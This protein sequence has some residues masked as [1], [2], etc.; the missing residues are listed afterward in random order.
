MTEPTL[1]PFGHATA[2]RWSDAAGSVVQQMGPCRSEHRLGFVYV[3]A[4][5]SEEL[6]NISIFLR[7][8]TGVETWVGTVGLGVCATGQEYFQ[9][10]AI[11]AMAVPID[12]DGFRLFGGVREDA[13]DV[14]KS[15]AE[16][17]A[18][19][20]MPLVVTHGDPGNRLLPALIEDLAEET[21]GFLVGGL[22][23]GMG[24]ARQLA[25][26]MEQDG[27]SGVML[28]P[29]AVQV[30]TGLT[31]GCTPIGPV[32]RITVAEDNVLIEIDERPALDV[33][34]EDI[35]KDMAEDLNKVAG[36]IYAGLPIEG[37]DVGDYTVRNLIGI[38]PENDMIAIGEHVEAGDTVLFCRRDQDSAVEDMKRMLGD[39]KRRANGAPIRGGLYFTCLARGANQF[40]PD[41][42]ELNMI[43]DELGSFP[44]VGFFGN[45]EI[46][47]DRLYSYTGVLTLFL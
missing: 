35:G 46:S 10:P 23:I 1:F 27:L 14:G 25:G 36:R 22:D 18:R 13:E 33:F 3:T 44:L 39:L 28:S 17:I 47:H 43:V 40:G 32:R 4:P 24:P 42:A 16:W 6:E 15:N 8:T 45:G 7:R 20:G 21:N 11:V 34:V 38:D 9:T 29:N 12:H 30:A 5:F 26:K 19:A 41:S 37:S 2:D 31:Q